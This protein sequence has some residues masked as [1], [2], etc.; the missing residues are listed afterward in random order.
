MSE[1]RSSICCTS[2]F[3]ARS[4]PRRLLVHLALEHGGREA[5]ARQRRAHLVRQR[6][7]HFLLR[8]DEL[9][10]ARRHV[11]EIG[12]EARELRGVLARCRAA[13]GS[14][15]RISAR[16]RS[17]RAGRAAAAAAT[18]RRSAGWTRRT[19]TGR[20]RM[21][22]AFVRRLERARGGW[23]HSA[24]AS[25]TGRRSC[26]S[27]LSSSRGPAS[28]GTAPEMSPASSRLISRSQLLRRAPR[29]ARRAR[30]AAPPRARIP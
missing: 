14:R 24:P 21:S 9:A 26:R 19:A 27:S 25:S 18:G 30:P 28:A 13:R 17:A 16:R 7:G 29:R 22:S 4:W 10:H 3:T 23:R 8:L 20:K 12:G 6:R 11:V 1:I 5:H 15:S 2:A